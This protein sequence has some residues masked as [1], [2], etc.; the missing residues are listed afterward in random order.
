ML[1]EIWGHLSS[2]VSM[3]TKLSHRNR[4]LFGQGKCITD[5]ICSCQSFIQ[6]IYS[7]LNLIL[8]Q[9][10]IV[11]GAPFF[12]YGCQTY[13]SKDPGFFPA[14]SVGG[15]DSPPLFRMGPS[16]DAEFTYDLVKSSTFRQLHRFYSLRRAYLHSVYR[17][18]NLPPS[19]RCVRPSADGGRPPRRNA[20][21]SRP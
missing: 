12:Y 1:F 3:P 10:F 21:G 19:P 4:P 20:P 7:E 17:P 15:G 5:L 18:C 9:V 13:Q 2:R 6:N 11:D 8:E 14:R 16:H